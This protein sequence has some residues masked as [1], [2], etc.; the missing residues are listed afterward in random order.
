MASRIV[1]RDLDRCLDWLGDRAG[2]IGYDMVQAIGLEKDGELVSVTGYKN[3]TEKACHIHFAIDKGAYPTREYIWFIHYYPFIQVG[4]DVLIGIIS[5]A[6]RG[7]VNLTR[8]MGYIEQCKIEEAGLI[9]TTLS[10][11]NCKWMEI[12]NGRQ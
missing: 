6:N 4:I 12:N 3:F 2:G 9:V 7:I 5:D 1:D 11:T 8:R 10:K